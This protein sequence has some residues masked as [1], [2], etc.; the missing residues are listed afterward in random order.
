MIPGLDGLRAISVLSVI[1]FH[2]NS[3]QFGF[4]WLG[5]QFF[6]VLSGFLITGILLRMKENL[7]VGQY[8]YKFYGRR[9]LRIFPLYYFYL[10][11]IVV[12]VWQAGS[13]VFAPYRSEL[14]TVVR[15]QLGHAFLYLYN[16][17]Y[18]GSN[19]H[20]TQFLNHFWSL[21]VEE[22]FYIFWPVLLLLT[23]KK[24]LKT[25]FLV[26]I[27]LG[28]FFRLVTYWVYTYQ[29]FPFL[30]DTA[31]I[32][33]YALPFSHID[34]FAMG[35]YI[36]QFD[37]PK[38]R[39]QLLLF[40]LLVPLLGYLAQYLELGIIDLNS[41]GYEFMLTTSYKFI[42]G[43]SLLNF[44]FMLVLY[45]V[46][47]SKLFIRALEHFTLRYIGK[48]SYGM[49]IYHNAVIYFMA[50]SAQFER[51]TSPLEFSIFAT[52]ITLIISSLSFYVLEKPIT[53]LKD[54]F[55]PIR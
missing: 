46:Y 18:A 44:F 54:K 15:P 47:R 29:V 24:N 45:N 30:G 49:Y 37:I 21:S 41:L 19:F 50:E 22:Q 36:S 6:F 26:T 1:V 25:L 51:L 28:P 35:A 13:Q 23:P 11:I 33:I 31:H 43:Y 40:G 14:Q 12:L 34:A 53:D 2:V 38:P 8:F 48:I 20:A 7:L 42:W 17:F 10:L 9:F 55:F 16:F 52:L 27:A 32:G 3:I 39:K 5:V 4:G